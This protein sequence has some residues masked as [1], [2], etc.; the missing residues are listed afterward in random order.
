M[1]NNLKSIKLS[2]PECGEKIIGRKD[3]KF[4]SDQCRTAHF[5]KMYCDQNKFMKNVNNILRKNRRILQHLIMGRS[6]KVSQTSL[7]NEGF[8][9]AYFTNEFITKT[10]KKYRFCYEFGYVPID[11]NVYTIVQRKEYVE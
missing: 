1:E 5:N 2:C 4:C 9:F 11:N 10:G 6:T 8:R 3:K 7:L